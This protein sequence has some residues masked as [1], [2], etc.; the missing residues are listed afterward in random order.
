MGSSSTR[1]A[2]KFSTPLPQPWQRLKKDSA[3]ER[4]VEC[5]VDKS[6]GFKV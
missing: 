1:V 5:P 3:Q 2:S 4:V 6:G